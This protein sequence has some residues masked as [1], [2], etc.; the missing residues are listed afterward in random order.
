MGKSEKTNYF[1]NRELSWLKFNERVLDEAVD[2]SVPVL[3]K[4]KFI[5]IFCSNLDEFFMIRVG[6]LCDQSFLTTFQND[7]KTGL[8]PSEQLD[9]IYDNIRQL[10]K[11]KKTIYYTVMSELSQKNIKMIN[12]NLLDNTELDFLTEYFRE[13]ILPFLSPSIIDSKHPFPHIENKSM[14]IGVNLIGKNKRH[15]G[16]IPVTSSLDRVIKVPAPN[17]KLSFVLLEDL[18]LFFVHEVFNIYRIEDKFIF[19]ISRNA[20]LE[21]DSEYSDEEIDYRQFL[22]ELL[23]KRKRLAPVRLEI[24][25]A[26]SKETNEYFCKR[27]GITPNQI[28]LDTTQFDCSWIQTIIDLAPIEIKKSLLFDRQTPQIPVGIDMKK[29][30]IPQILS[31]DLLLSYPYE[32][33]KPFLLFLK[34]A[35]EDKNTVSIKITLYRLSSESKVIQYLINAAE[36]GKDVTAIVELRARFDE[37]N[38]IQWAT[39]LE[40]AGCRVVYGFEMYKVHSKILLVNRKINNHI[41]TLTQIGTGNYNENTARLYTD[42]SL[43]T[44]NQ[45]IGA[46]ATEYFKNM[47]IGS[48]GVSYPLLLVAPTNFKKRILEL[49]DGEINFAKTGKTGYI[50]MKF[51]S[52]TDKDLIDK[53]VEASKNG[54][55][56]DLIIRG[57][58][59]LLP[60]L[61]GVTDNINIISIVGRY[62]EHSRVFCFGPQE[63]MSLYISSADLMTRNTLRR[64]EIACPVF[65]DQVRLRIFEMLNIMLRDNTKA[66]KILPDGNYIYVR[67]EEEKIDSQTY[68]YEQALK[69][70]KD[71]AFNQA[72]SENIKKYEEKSQINNSFLSRMRF[73]KESIGK[74]FSRKDKG[75]N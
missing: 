47:L 39:R 11:K 57:I 12:L 72:K 25:F 10:L 36:S 59:C 16:I 44:S 15:F 68:F 26:V 67:N 17:G 42:F 45:M 70:A 38:N 51:N 13:N 65:D 41:H 40:E 46:D 55:K 60:N 49:I 4:L 56:I 62:L 22:T 27:L 14:N 35:C 2:S 5:S 69:N 53:L 58:C 75:R 3:E 8:T 74:L 24:S 73:L 7:N 28:F 43:I 66:R 61:K 37:E 18:I 63:R 71:E 50:L 6:S 52:L 54:V 33:M 32:S 1:I 23:K 30:L 21:L 19:R 34:E 9:L 48:T 29:P 64:F 31:K 20:D